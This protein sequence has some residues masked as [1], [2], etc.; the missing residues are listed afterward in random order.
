M[1]H[2][3]P[4]L[5]IKPLIS[6]KES[7]ASVCFNGTNILEEKHLEGAGAVAL[8]RGLSATSGFTLLD[9]NGTVVPVADHCEFDNHG[10]ALRS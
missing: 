2:P 9:I 5:A 7:G 6:S 10:L 3:L 1:C 4:P 8:G